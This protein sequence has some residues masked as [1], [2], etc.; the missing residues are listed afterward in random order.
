M[1]TVQDL[2]RAQAKGPR[3]L[4]LV[5][6]LLTFD[7]VPINYPVVPR[8]TERGGGQ[9]IVTTYGKCSL[10]AASYKPLK[11]RLIDAGFVIERKRINRDAI[12]LVWPKIW[13]DDPDAAA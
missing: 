4:E 1:S 5:D 9:Q 7:L 12:L 13:E 3:Q 6:E 11:K 10:P 8:P 2:A